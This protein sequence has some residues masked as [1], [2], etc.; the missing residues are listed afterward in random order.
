MAEWQND[1]QMFELM[2]RDLYSPVVGDVLDALGFYHQILPPEIMPMTDTMTLIG[3]A[4]PVA[5][6]DV[7]GPQDRPFG[8]LTQALDQIRPGEV[9][10]SNG[11]Q[12]RSALWGELLTATARMRGASGAIV[13]GYHRDTPRVLEQ[14]WPVFSRGRFCQDSGV[15]TMVVDYRV[16]V[17]IGGIQIAPGDLV[18]GDLDGVVVIPRSVEEEVI[19]QALR[20]ARAEALVRQDIETAC[21]AQKPLKNTECYDESS[22]Q[23]SNPWQSRATNR[24]G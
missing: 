9:W 6:A 17:E 13:D 15:R 3:R 2:K 4:M 14:G 12:R 7:F 5:I 16:P 19:S 21:R 8:L 23:R 24:R 11:G 10:V 18:F 1:Q 20:K 22:R